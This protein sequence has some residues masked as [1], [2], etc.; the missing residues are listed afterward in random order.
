MRLYIDI[1]DTPLLIANDFTVDI[2]DEIFITD[3]SFLIQIEN[4]Y[5][6]PTI[7]SAKIYEY[8]CLD[9]CVPILVLDCLLDMP[10]YFADDNHLIL[11]IDGY[12]FA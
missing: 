7:L 4:E 8:D 6:T 10:E 9:G 5:L 11:T 12:T 1:L 3:K 2:F